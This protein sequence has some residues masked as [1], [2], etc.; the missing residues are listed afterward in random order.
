MRKGLIVLCAV[1]AAGF[2]VST[3]SSKE[4]VKM[5][6]LRISSPAFENNGS[7][8]GKYTCDGMDV[9]PPL[10]IANVPAGARSLAL[11]V[12]DPDAPRGTWVHWV[13]W[14]IGPKTLEIGENT[15]PKGALQAVNDFKRHQYGGPCPP[16]GTHRYFFKLY[17]LDA[18]LNFS[19][20]SGKA[21][22]EKAMEGHII[23]RA[24]IVGLYKRQ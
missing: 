12:D 16:S 17:A 5:E 14:N 7:I 24:E 19:A 22:L 20:N 4:G 15:V 23:A 2:L 21:G 8:P 9:N 6:T 13:V 3:A 18:M 11:I 1:T 10:R